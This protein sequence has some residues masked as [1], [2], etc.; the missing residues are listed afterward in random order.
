MP[1]PARS[2]RVNTL[3]GSRCYRPP[4]V[5]RAVSGPS[6]G[7]VVR[8]GCVR[9]TW[10]LTPHSPAAGLAARRRR[11]VGPRRHPARV[12][13]S[14][15]VSGDGDHG[16][17][18]LPLNRTMLSNHELPYV[19]RFACDWPRL[20]TTDPHAARRTS[21]PGR[22]GERRAQRPR[23]PG[24]A[25]LRPG[26]RHSP[27]PRGHGDDQPEPE[28]RGGQRQRRPA[29]PLGRTA[30]EAQRR[31]VVGDEH[32]V[33][34]PAGARPPRTWVTTAAGSTPTPQPAWRARQHRS[35]SSANMKYASS[36]PPSSSKRGA[37][38]QEARARHP[39]G[40]GRLVARRRRAGGSGG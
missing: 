25:R 38:G 33:G 11:P 34:V 21:R 20:A 8:S 2:T 14:P 7:A 26:Q 19:G 13:P 12:P 16:G 22:P 40:L 5:V 9:L 35:M 15:P 30:G 17:Q 23:R 27:A 39:V 31:A 18:G 32:P 29:P 1:S 6:T 10:S 24:A 36:K 37:A 4:G 28:H 3:M